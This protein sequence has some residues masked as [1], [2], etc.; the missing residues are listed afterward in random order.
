MPGRVLS[1]KTREGTSGL[2]GVGCR[3]VSGFITSTEE[4]EN[5]RKVGQGKVLVVL[6]FM[7]GPFKTQNHH[8]PLPKII[9]LFAMH[10][11]LDTRILDKSSHVVFVNDLHGVIQLV[12]VSDSP[13]S[14]G[15][16]VPH[17]RTHVRLKNWT[18][19]PTLASITLLAAYP[20]ESWLLFVLRKKDSEFVVVLRTRS[21]EV[22]VLF[23]E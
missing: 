16:D 12:Q 7:I 6:R 18:L 4:L 13:C 21:H 15:K 3:K 14:R 2:A 23:A 5:H 1:H 10:C 22:E 17:I 11:L 19:A 20:N 9:V 8:I